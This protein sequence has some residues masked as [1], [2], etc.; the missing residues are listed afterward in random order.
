MYITLCANHLEIVNHLM[1]L[2]LHKKYF[3]LCLFLGMFFSV[4][5][6]YAIENDSL[7]IRDDESIRIDSIY[8]IGNEK[9]QDFIIL[10]ELNF[11]SGETVS[12]RT[13][14]YNR[15]RIFSLRLFSRVDFIIHKVAN[16][17]ILTIH[18]YET[19]Y[20]YPFP[21]IAMESREV[22]KA[23]YGLS[24]NYRN[25]RG[26]N[27]TLRT[28]FGFGYD[29]FYNLIYENPSLSYSDGIGMV[30]IV[31]YSHPTNRSPE[32]ETI[33][34]DVYQNR[35]FSQSVAI[36]KRFNQYNL[37]DFMVGFNYLEAPLAQA[38]LTATGNRIDRSLFAGINYTYDTRGLKQFSQEGFYIYTQII[39]KGFNIDGIDYNLLQL[40]YREYR[41]IFGD[42]AGKWRIDYSRAFGKF[43]PYYDYSFLGYIERVR[44]H[45]NDIREGLGYILTSVEFSYPL[46][47]EWDVSLKIPLIPES[48]TS[49][50]LG[51]YLTSFFDAGDAFNNENQIS[52]NG[53]YSGYGV[54]LTLLVL[55]YSAVR[56]EFAMNE[57]G[58]G[59]FLIGGGFSF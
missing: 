2:N 16:G 26:R 23:T 31:S 45:M 3:L 36:S 13:L 50:R 28:S 55:P 14:R 54:G 57:L 27:E 43:V 9:T 46:V 35:I 30:L 41:K 48:L 56:F 38:G 15:E 4:T 20:I 47:K 5:N 19:W 6:F 7:N 37:A 24:L 29:P 11:N 21:V 17:N 22:K 1:N 34:G 18:V 10:R 49:A 44:G 42:F 51:I 33:V 52:F 53:F 40:D 25:F 12:G 32:A 59:E 58:R 8:V 39:H